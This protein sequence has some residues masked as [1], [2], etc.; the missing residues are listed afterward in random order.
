M[1]IGQMF[2][3]ITFSIMTYCVSSSPLL[4]VVVVGCME[5]SELILNGVLVSIVDSS[6]LEHIT[7]LNWLQ[8]NED[9]L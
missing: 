4:Q 9:M 7:S 3:F 1:L 5:V 8:N 6:L 2:G